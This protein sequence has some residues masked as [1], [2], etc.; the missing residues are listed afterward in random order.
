MP[1]FLRVDA[2]LLRERLDSIWACAPMA[3]LR[4]ARRYYCR[5]TAA[6]REAAGVHRAWDIRSHYYI[7]TRPCCATV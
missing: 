7:P 1:P 3:W 5:M 4:A 6:Q 2:N